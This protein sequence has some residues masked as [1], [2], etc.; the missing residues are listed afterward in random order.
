MLQS[1][2]KWERAAKTNI[3]LASHLHKKTG[4]SISENS[5]ERQNI[6]RLIHTY[7]IVHIWKNIVSAL[8]V[9]ILIQNSYRQK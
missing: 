2:D 4:L 6:E 5:G 8:H 9:N 7:T 3:K 1:R